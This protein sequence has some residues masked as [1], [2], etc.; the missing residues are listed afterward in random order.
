MK[1]LFEPI[2]LWMR[3]HPVQN[4]LFSAFFAALIIFA[5]DHDHLEHYCFMAFVGGTL[6]WGLSAII[7]ARKDMLPLLLVA[8]LLSSGAGTARSQSA[9]RTSDPQHGAS[10][11][12]GVVVICIG[13]YCCYRLYKFCQKAFPKGKTNSTPEE[14]RLSSGDEYGGSWSYDALGSCY[15][16]QPTSLT[17][18]TGYPTTFTIH[19][20]VEPESL[21]VKTSWS[22]NEDD[23]QSFLQFQ[24]EVASHG[25]HVSQ[26]ADGVQRFSRNRTPVDAGTVPISF[27]PYRR[28]VNVGKSYDR[29]T[30]IVERSHD[31]ERWTPFLK[32]DVDVGAGFMIVDTSMESQT[33][34]RVG[35]A[36]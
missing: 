29:R 27:D 9:S 13:G 31:L 20:K 16:P 35:V 30:V 12:A 5:G 1:H 17:S 33:F 19:V 21:A 14:F 24:N 22:R 8:A 2:L 34:Y 10:V 28:S 26:Y 25:L 36:P 4:S 15:D 23:A 3:K 11:A 32:T 7:T 18:D 6:L